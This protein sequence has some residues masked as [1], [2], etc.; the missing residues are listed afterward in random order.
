[1]VDDQAIL[2]AVEDFVHRRHCDLTVWSLQGIDKEDLERIQTE[3]DG[4]V[5]FEVQDVYIEEEKDDTYYVSTCFVFLVTS[6]EPIE[7]DPEVYSCYDDHG[8]FVVEWDHS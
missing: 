1:M 6:G 7:C 5:C 3:D 8:K 4:Y 2:K